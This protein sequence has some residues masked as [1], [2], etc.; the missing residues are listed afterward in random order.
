[1]NLFVY[2]TLKKDHV[3]DDFYIYGRL[4]QVSSWFPGA[5]TGGY[6]DKIWGQLT[7]V[8]GE[9]LEYLDRYEGCPHLFN[10]KIVR[11]YNRQGLFAGMAYVYE[12][13]GDI[14]DFDQIGGWKNENSNYNRS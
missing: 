7:K 5:K 14:K 11:A 10:R 3:T 8:T 9:D 6:R 1:M 2:G 4:Y 12:Y 13:S